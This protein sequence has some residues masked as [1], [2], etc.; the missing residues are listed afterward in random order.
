MERIRER[1]ERSLRKR[2]DRSE[3]SGGIGD[4]DSEEDNDGEINIVLRR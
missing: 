4:R 2:A 3:E 1:Y